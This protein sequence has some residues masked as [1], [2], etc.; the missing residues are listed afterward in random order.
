MQ[1]ILLNKYTPLCKLQIDTQDNYIIS[2]ILEIYNVKAFPVG[3]DIIRG[4]PQK[5]SLAK[6][7]AGRAIPGSRIGANSFEQRYNIK[8]AALPFKNYGLSLSD[9]YWLKPVDEDVT[10]DDINF[11]DNKFSLDI[12]K[13]FF[14]KTYTSVDLDFMSPDNTSDGML[15]KKWMRDESNGRLYLYKAGSG[16]FEQEPFNECIASVIYKKLNAVPFVKYEVINDCGSYFSVC[17]NFIDKNTELVTASNMMLTQSPVTTKA[18]NK[19]EYLLDCCS[20]FNIPNV[21]EQIDVMLAV[22][23]IIC[24]TDR[25]YGNFGFIRNVDDLQFL[26]CAP[27]YDNGTS[28][29]NLDKQADIGVKFAA[30]AFAN[31]QDQAVQLI[32]NFE[33]LDLKRLA[34]IDEIVYDILSKNENLSSE[35]V[36]FIA[37]AVKKQ[38]QK[39]QKIKDKINNK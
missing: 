10:W 6:W 20:K 31:T 14:D 13:A 35:R 9:Q 26:G 2:D 18:T 38:V 1:Y 32:T 22:D 25:H 24:N 8:L 5:K 4:V 19:Y 21:R 12:G 3:V 27:V 16:P 36:G 30:R 11:F 34:D 17:E 37:T 33:L 29:W 7:W 28:L 39:L 15:P 23:Y